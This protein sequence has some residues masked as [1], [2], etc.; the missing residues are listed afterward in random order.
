MASPSN[1]NSLA[2]S[3][4]YSPDFA[5]GGVYSEAGEKLANTT[6]AAPTIDPR[7]GDLQKSQAAAAD[8]YRTK[9]KNLAKDVYGGYRDDSNRALAENLN[10][11]KTNY[12]QRGLLYS[13]L[14]QGTQNDVRSTAASDLAQ[15]RNAINTQYQT[16]QDT[17]DQAPINTGI[18]AAGMGNNSFASYGNNSLL[19]QKQALYSQQQNLNA[20]SSLGTGLGQ[21]GGMAAAS[22]LSS[23]AS[24]G[25]GAAPN[26][27]QGY[28]S[29]SPLQSSMPGLTM[30]QI[31]AYGR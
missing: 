22:L 14:N 7:L 5:P 3:N 19:D 18:A 16:N 10:T 13:G 29:Y 17:L 26:Y 24:S 21:V 20:A 8:S 6:V 25:L 23:P 1:Y 9:G 15:K 30:P 11:V 2:G 27:L 4:R 28:N 31:N 12:N